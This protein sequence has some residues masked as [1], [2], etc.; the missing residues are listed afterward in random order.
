MKANFGWTGVDPNHTI[1]A[2]Q[3]IGAALDQHPELHDIPTK[4]IALAMLE[5]SYGFWL[6]SGGD[7]EKFAD[8]LTPENPTTERSRREQRE[9]GGDR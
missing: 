3:R 5:L 7:P 4:V 9:K 1:G 6:T 2:G 8:L